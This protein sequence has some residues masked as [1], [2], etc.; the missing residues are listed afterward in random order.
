MS[1]ASS[2][3]R[4]IACDCDLVVAPM[5]KLHWAWLCA[6]TGQNVPFPEGKI[7]PYNLGECFGIPERALDFWRATDL[8]DCV[9]PIAGSVE[10]LKKIS[11]TCDLVFVSAIKGN[12]TKSKYYFLKAHF[13]FM[14]GY[15]ATKEKYLVRCDAI[16]DDRLE[17]LS[18]MPDDVITIQYDTPYRQDVNFTPDLK[19]SDWGQV[20]RRLNEAA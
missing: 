19:F 5:D 16:I 6:E 3:R 4:I 9:L 8:Y 2:N 15:V 11:E 10:A 14:K 7:L 20:V 1:S 17:N 12:H 18:K 13:P